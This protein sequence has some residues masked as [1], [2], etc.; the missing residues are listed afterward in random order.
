MGDASLQDSLVAD[1]LTDAFHGYHM[2]VT[3]EFHLIRE[4]PCQAANQCSVVNQLR[5]WL[6]S[7]GSAES[8]RICLPSNP[9][10]E[11]RRRRKA[12]ISTERSFR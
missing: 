10:T 5:T 9:R 11:P 2:G 1:G 3:G 7:G 12:A 6:N 8:S 4:W